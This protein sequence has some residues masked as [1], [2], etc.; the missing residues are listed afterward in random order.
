MMMEIITLTCQL[1]RMY[2]VAERAYNDPDLC[3]GSQRIVQARYMHLERIQRV[4][5]RATPAI[6]AE[7]AT[8]ERDSPEALSARH[9]SRRGR[10]DKSETPVTEWV[11][12]LR[13]VPVVAV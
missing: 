2:V 10:D 6:M 12:V 3:G 11:V 4:Y 7:G 9:P 5:S 1:F 8:E 13:R